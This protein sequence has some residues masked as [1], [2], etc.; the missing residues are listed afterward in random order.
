MMMEDDSTLT[1]MQQRA[2][3]QEWS[4]SEVCREVSTGDE[5]DRLLDVFER[6]GKVF[7]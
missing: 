7:T 4:R 1:A 5:L 2:T 6:I 3:R